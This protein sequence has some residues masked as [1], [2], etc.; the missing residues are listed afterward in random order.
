L[1]SIGMKK[2]KDQQIQELEY[3]MAHELKQKLFAKEMSLNRKYIKMLD[4]KRCKMILKQEQEREKAKK[5]IER[6][7]ETK[8]KNKI[9]AIKWH[10]LVKYKSKWKTL[11]KLKQDLLTALQKYVRLRDSNEAWYWKCI[12]CENIR[13]YKWCDGGHYLSRRLNS[14]AFDLDNIHLQCK[15]CNGFKWWAPIE[16]RKWLIEKIGIK[17]VELLESKK[18]RIVTLDRDHM[19]KEIKKWKAINKKL[20]AQKV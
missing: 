6:Q 17:K 3:K 9:R 11:P 20:E 10:K 18:H 5:K 15:T 14:V 12:S 1:Y 13:H 4:T 8:L 16:Y 19:I 2:T 7:V